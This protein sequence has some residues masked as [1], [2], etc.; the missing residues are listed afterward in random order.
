MTTPNAPQRSAKR[1]AAQ[2][3]LRAAIASGL[4]AIAVLAFSA[5]SAL[6]A[7]SHSVIED[8]FS[9]GEPCT[10]VWDIAVLEPEGLVYV[11]CNATPDVIKRFDLDGNPVPFSGSAPYITGNTLTGDPVSDDGTF[12]YIPDIAVDSSPSGNHGRLFVTS[13][14]NVDVFA[15]S[16]L[17]TAT[18][19]QPNESTIDNRIDGIDIGPDG[20]IYVTSGNPGGRVTKYNTSFQELKR[21]YSQ[22]DTF[23]NQHHIRIDTTGALWSNPILNAGGGVRKYEADQFTDELKPKLGVPVPEFAFAVPSPFAPNP[24]VPQLQFSNENPKGIDVDLSD[25][26]VYVVRGPGAARVET[27]SQGVPGELAYRNAPN[28]GGGT[29]V[30]PTAVEVTPDHRVYVSSG[31]TIYRFGPGDILP[32]VRTE[33]PDIDEIGHEDALVRGEVELAGGTNITN[34]KVE[35]GLTTS[36]GSSVQCDPDAAESPPGSNFS[37]DTPVTAQITGLNTGTTYH[38][39]ITAENEDGANS[40]IDRVVTPAY[41]LKLQTLPASGVNPGGATLNASLD[42]DG[43]ET[44]YKFQYGLTQSYDFETEPESAGSGNGVTSVGTELSGLPSGKIFHY[45]V[46][47][48]NA[49]GTTVGSD[50]TFRTASP[51]DISG[52]RTTEV[53]A[54][55]A[56]LHAVVNPVGFDTEYHFEYGPT[57]DYGSSIPPE[58]ENIGSGGEPVPVTQKIEGLQPGAT[59]HFRIVAENQWGPSESGDTTFD[60][61]PPICPNAHVRQQT[62]SSYLPDCRAYELVSPP[63]VGAALLLPSGFIGDTGPNTAYSIGLA[64]TITNRGFATSPSR[65]T[66]WTAI[67]TIEGLNSPV[68]PYDMFMATRTSKGWVTQV[69]GLQGNDA[70]ETSRKECSESMHLCIDHQETSELGYTQENA[71]YVYTAD[72]ESRGRLPTNVHI[73]PG[74][75]R[76]GGGQVM[77]GDFSHFAFSSTELQVFSGVL[78][79]AVFAPGGLSTG[80]GS[81]YDNDID[82][83]TVTII[84]KLPNGEDF[85]LEAPKTPSQKGI[86]FRGITPDGSHILMETPGIG[87]SHLFMRVNQTVTYDISRGASVEPIG[88]TRDGG[89]VFFVTGAQLTGDDTDASTDLY[90]WEEDG[91]GGPDELTRISQGNGNGDVDTC[92]AA[93]GVSGCGVKPL[94]PERAHP[95]SGQLVSMPGQDDLFAEASGDIYFYSPELLDPTSPGV[96][97]QRNL[98]VYRNGSVQLVATFDGGTQVSRMQISPDGRFAAMLTDSQLVSYDNA[99]WDQVYSYDVD[100]D[101]IR[102]VSCNPSGL[103]PTANATVSQGGRFMANDGRTFFSTPDRLVPRDQNGEITDTYEYVGGRPQLISSGLGAKDYTG[104]GEILSLFVPNQFIGLE[105][106]SRDGTDVYFSTFE[107][108][109][110][111][112]LNGEF[113]KFYNARTGGGFPRDPGLADCAA[114]DECHGPDSSPPAPPLVASSGVLGSGGNVAT[115]KKRKA[116]RKRVKRKRKHHRSQRHRKGKRRHARHRNG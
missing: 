88:M 74:G 91:A 23:F 7:F 16:G 10:E 45:R 58:P 43:M 62:T 100:A 66:F 32:D 115:P 15:P 50:R 35:Y 56:V 5:P 96:L 77:S 109:L 89:K 110:D 86:D 40:G 84:S 82:A 108:L 26:D 61:S 6:G 14:P 99:G 22:A 72:G 55:S 51:P 54:T 103:P 76:F 106:V 81:A 49:N 37:T 44:S 11:S 67:S 17:Y 95:N 30:N 94:T 36:Y 105:H 97:N 3:R 19:D 104:G 29:L 42:P 27:Y 101:V 2:A 24:V 47:A 21:L 78:E 31:T 70:F 75:T 12:L 107:T 28:F 92:S 98:Y 68:G 113:V 53:T 4:M 90:M 1:R 46:I 60:F 85:Q 38:Y 93:W 33:E 111:E 80:L 8:E 79:G 73:V 69:P 13:S 48:S 52:V 83:R 71:P 112:D 59:Y 41:V 39:R 18:I 9:I 64:P 102:C 25:N 116:K 20:L 65:F 87:G 34:C 57:P 63:S 114:A